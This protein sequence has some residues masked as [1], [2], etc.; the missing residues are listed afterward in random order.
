MLGAFVI[1]GAAS[2]LLLGWEYA[3][4]IGWVVAAIVYVAWVWG[5][6]A[7]LDDKATAQRLVADAWGRQ[8]DF[9]GMILQAFDAV[10]NSD[11]VEK[12]AIVGQGL[13]DAQLCRPEAAIDAIRACLGWTATD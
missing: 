5:T 3:P 9:E 6:I 2:G 13:A 1:A 11:Q 4:T 12:L 8:P 10:L 7:R